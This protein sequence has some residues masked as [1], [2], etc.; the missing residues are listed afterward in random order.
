MTQVVD[1]VNF[2]LYFDHYKYTGVTDWDDVLNPISKLDGEPKVVSPVKQSRD[3][4]PEFYSNIEVARHGSAAVDMSDGDSEDSNYIDS[5]YD[6]EDGDDDLF[7][8]NEDE[9]VIDGGAGREKKM[10]KGKE[11][12]AG[13][14]VPTQTEDN[15][16]EDFNF[17]GES[18]GEREMKLKFRSFNPDDLVNPT[19]RVGMVFSTMELLRK[20]IT[21]YSLK[22]RVDI[23]MSRNDKTRVKA[24]CAVGCPWGLYASLDSRANAFMVKTYVADHN[25]KK[26]WYLKRCIAKWSSEK[27]IESFR[28]DEKI[29]LDSFSRIVQKEWNLT[30]SRSKL[31]RARRMALD[32]IYGDEIDQFNLICDFGNELRRSNPGSTFLCW[33]E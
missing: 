3:K 28:T 9:E 11:A 18:D 22:H 15:T 31:S 10:S 32:K 19:F 8:D 29:S 23:K 25:C 7:V 2:V 4:L 13:P 6:L 12:S 26:E 14:S 20:A 5:D 1:S 30:P 16:D 33:F 17:D 24:H 21:E 27:Y